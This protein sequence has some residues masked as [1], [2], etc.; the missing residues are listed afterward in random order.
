MRYVHIMMVIWSI[1]TIISLIQIM[2]LRVTQKKSKRLLDELQEQN[3]IVL[4]LIDHIKEIGD[5][6]VPSKNV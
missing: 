5:Q 1:A 3:K 4:A 2:R 6:N